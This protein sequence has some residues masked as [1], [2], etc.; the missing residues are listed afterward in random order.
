MGMSAP[1]D[2]QV[3]WLDQ[4]VSTMASTGYYSE[5][6]PTKKFASTEDF[7]LPPSVIVVFVRHR[8]CSAYARLKVY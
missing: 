4:I 3:R 8:W 2:L 5:T 1:K 6:A 7:E